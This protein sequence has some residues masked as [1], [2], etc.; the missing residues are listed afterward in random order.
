MSHMMPS[1]LRNEQSTLPI[2]PAS[3]NTMGSTFDGYQHSPIQTMSPN[4]SGHHVSHQKSTNESS[5]YA[6][7]QSDPRGGTNEARLTSEGTPRK[8]RRSRKGL[9]KRFDCLA[10]GCG[11]SYSRAEHL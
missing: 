11:K 3:S 9:S 2:S 5:P 1:H 6:T 7:S 4:M 10:E 8:K